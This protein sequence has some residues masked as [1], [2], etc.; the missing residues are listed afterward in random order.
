[1]R[2]LNTICST[3]FICL[4]CLFLFYSQAQAEDNRELTI[5]YSGNTY[6]KIK[7]CPS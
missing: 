3:F 7:P 4:L 5:I 1:M 2:Y 6:G